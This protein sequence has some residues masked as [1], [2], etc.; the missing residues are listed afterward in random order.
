[1]KLNEGLSISKNGHLVIGDMDVLDIV[2][3]YPTPV[4][5]LNE[6]IIRKYA[7]EFHDE[8]KKIMKIHLFVMLQRRI[9]VRQYFK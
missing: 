4:Y 7:R 8:L 6:E 5:V 9:A 2:Q 3:K 1:M